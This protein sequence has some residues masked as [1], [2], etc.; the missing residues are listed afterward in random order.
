[1]RIL[2]SLCYLVPVLW[3]TSAQAGHGG[4]APA[5]REWTSLNKWA[6]KNN[7]KLSWLKKNESAFLASESAKMSF[8]IDSQL[9]KIN[10]V[11]VWLC[12]PVALRDGQACISSLDLR[13]SIQPI[14]F[15]EEGDAG[16][17]IKTICLDPGHGGKDTGGKVGTHLEKRYTLLL[18]QELE[19]RMRAVGLKVLLTRNRDRFVELENRPA[20]ANRPKADLFISLHFNIARPG[21]AKGVEVYCLTPAKASSTNARGQGR[22]AGSLPGN[23]HDDRNVLLAYELQKALVRELLTEDR[24]LRRARFAVLREAQM[25]AVLVEGGFLSD[26]EERN[27]I[28]DPNYRRRMAEAILLGVLAYR[29]IVES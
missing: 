11:N 25:P 4:S 23:R 3:T 16:N 9:A 13:R 10:R 19:K 28:A 8:T 24:G 7:F 27:R 1:M 5:N 15:P 22:D 29:R 26:P 17:P 12:D 6:W 18:A 2:Q 14:L 21:E 20:L